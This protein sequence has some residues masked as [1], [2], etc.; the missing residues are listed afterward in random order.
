MKEEDCTLLSLSDCRSP[1]TDSD[2][3]RLGRTKLTFSHIHD[4]ACQ[5]HTKQH[6][7]NSSSNCSNNSNFN[8]NSTSNINSSTSIKDIHNTH[9]PTGSK[10]TTKNKIT[11]IALG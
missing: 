8:N 1:T 6:I 10:I 9:T 3:G 2:Q 5:C 11:T 4:K 7:R